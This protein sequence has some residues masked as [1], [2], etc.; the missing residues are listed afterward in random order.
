MPE[1]SIPHNTAHTSQAASPTIFGIKADGRGFSLLWAAPSLTFAV[2]PAVIA[3]QHEDPFMSAGLALLTLLLATVY[4]SVW[5][6][7]PTPA[8]GA[9]FTGRFVVSHL[10]LLLVSVALFFWSLA[11]GNDGTM[12]HMLAY[13]FAAWIMQAPR[14]R[15]VLGVVL[16]AS[17]YGLFQWFY[18]P[19]AGFPYGAFMSTVMTALARVSIEFGIRKDAQQKH[20]LSIAHEQERLRIGA[21]LHDILGH[22]LTAIVM[23]AQIADRLLATNQT[24]AAREQVEDLLALSRSSLAEVRAVVSNMRSLRLD[25]ELTHATALLESA[26]IS[27]S[28]DSQGGPPLGPATTV[29]ARVLRESVTNI[30]AH[31]KAKKV[32]IHLSPTLLMIRNDGYSSRLAAQTRGAATGLQGLRESMEGL[33]SLSWHAEGAYWVLRAELS[34]SFVAEEGVR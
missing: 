18:A 13:S 15:V 16:G 28:L 2:L 21:D 6:L 24:E 11:M 4:V 26:G 33:G 1:A 12:V 25:D 5:L 9:S 14:R 19:N 22:S 17:V 31:S 29:F 27:V 23:K 32:Q 10:L 30:L 34:R 3:Y 7:N 8:E 20:M